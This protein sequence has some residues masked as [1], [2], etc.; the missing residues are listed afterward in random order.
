MST[1]AELQGVGADHCVCRG[2]DN[3][4]TLKSLAIVRALLIFR[5]VSG[6]EDPLNAE[7]VY[8]ILAPP[9]ISL[10]RSHYIQ[11]LKIITNRQHRIFPN[12]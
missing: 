5:K 9:S 1:T 7:S 3:D 6:Q 4:L 11:N 8:S 10:L 2:R 12:T